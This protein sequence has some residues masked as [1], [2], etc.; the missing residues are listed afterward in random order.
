[1][2]KKLII[3]CALVV[4]L[5][6][7]PAVSADDTP[8]IVFPVA[9]EVE[10]VNSWGAARSGG[11]SHKGTDIMADKLV[12]VVATADGVIDWIHDGIRKRCCA[13]G[14]LHDDG[15]E[16][17]YIHM[18]NDTPGTDDGRASGF[19]P[20]IERGTRVVAGQIIGW[21]GDSGNA[22]GTEPHIHFE[23]HRPGGTP[24]NPYQALDDAT[25][26]DLLASEQSIAEVATAIG[27]TSFPDEVDTVFVVAAQNFDAET[28]LTSIG[29]TTTPTFVSAEF[30]LTR[31]TW[32]ELDRLNPARIVIVGDDVSNVLY[33]QLEANTGATISRVSV[34]DRAKFNL[35]E[36]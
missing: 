4:A 14:I 30:G 9:G 36:M 25:P 6:P 32:H 1:M 5:L 3:A 22:E 15:W 23:L 27:A 10:F 35:L 26:A 8:K 7:L 28:A 34:V 16:S 13:L 24:V 21:V 2:I 20:G 31:Q 33:R 19:A 18:N 17:W 29:E 11:R 12:P